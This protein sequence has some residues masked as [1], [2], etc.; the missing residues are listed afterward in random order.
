MVKRTRAVA[1]AILLFSGASALAVGGHAPS[2][3]ADPSFDFMRRWRRAR[4]AEA[5]RLAHP[6]LAS[7]GVVPRQG[8]VGP[9]IPARI[10]VARAAAAQRRGGIGP[11]FGPEAFAG[12]MNTTVSL[13]GVVRGPNYRGAPLPNTGGVVALPGEYSGPEFAPEVEGSDL[14]S[15]IPDLRSVAL[16]RLANPDATTG[17]SGGASKPSK[18]VA[19]TAPQGQLTLQL[20][21]VRPRSGFRAGDDVAIR[22]AA[23]AASYAA[24]IRV[25]ATG[26]AAVAFKSPGPSTT[27]GCVIQT[28]PTAG[29]EYYVAIASVKPLNGADVAAALRSVGMTYSSAA[30]SPEGGLQP[31]A[32]W[33]SAVLF[34]AGAFPGAPAGAA[35]W[36]RNEFAVT[37][38]SVAVRTSQAVATAKKP[39]P[40]PAKSTSAAPAP[41]PASPTPAPAESVVPTEAPKPV[42]PPADSEPLKENSQTAPAPAPTTPSV[43]GAKWDLP[44]TTRRKPGARP[45]GATLE[46][47]PVDVREGLPS[48]ASVTGVTAAIVPES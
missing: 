28:G 29:S 15:E 37:G 5:Y 4:A 3:Q 13:H 20:S 23:S 17:A 43:N 47:L 46:L 36:Q 7:E 45:N 2:V 24:V 30:P 16:S 44:P 25:D 39:A 8:F 34:A 38:A 42:P 10:V 48:I 26:K 21:A 12:A 35:R 32:A 6:E 31:A 9:P 40:G 22:L 19:T 11:L 1:T 18:G 27:F 14:S 33:N 41:K